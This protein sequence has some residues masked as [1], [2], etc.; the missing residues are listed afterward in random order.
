V[1][2]DRNLRFVAALGGPPWN[3]NDPKY[4]ADDEAGRLYVADEYNNR[5]VVLAPGDRKIIL[6]IAGF[7]SPAGADKLNQPEGV[8][9]RGDTLWIS[10]TYNDR[11]LAFRVRW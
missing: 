8:A 3:F 11:I 1:T 5:V 2:L 9:V 6:T 10:D 7:A 4:V